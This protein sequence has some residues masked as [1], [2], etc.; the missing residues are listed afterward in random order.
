MELDPREPDARDRLRGGREPPRRG[1]LGV[2]VVERRHV[3]GEAHRDIRRVDRRRR[4]RTVAR[5]RRAA[6]H[7]PRGVDHDLHEA[8]AAPRVHVGRREAPVRD[9][10]EREVLGR[11]RGP[12]ELPL[13]VDAIVL[14]GAELDEIEQR[15]PR[16]R[17]ERRG[18]AVLERPFVGGEPGER[19]DGRGPPGIEREPVVA[20]ERLRGVAVAVGVP[21]QVASELV[22]ALARGHDEDA[23]ECVAVLRVHAARHQLHAGHRPDRHLCVAAP[24]HIERL[25]AVDLDLEILRAAPAHMRL[26]VR[27]HDAGLRAEH[28]H[29]A[30]P[31]VGLE[32]VATHLVARADL[33][34][35]HASLV[36]VAHHRLERVHDALRP[37]LN[38]ARR[39]PSRLDAHARP[40]R[41]VPGEQRDHLMLARGNAIE[42]VAP[43][44][45]GHHLEPEPGELHRRVLPR[46]A[47]T[48]PDDAADRSG[49]GGGRS[50][51]GGRRAG[52]QEEHQGERERPNADGGIASQRHA[53]TPRPRSGVSRFHFM[54]RCGMPRLRAECGRTASTRAWCGRPG[55]PA[56]RSEGALRFARRR[57]GVKRECVRARGRAAGAVSAAALPRARGPRAPACSWSDPPAPGTGR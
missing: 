18:G 14:A 9:P 56:A 51:R 26:A 24:Q 4:P 42:A 32:V 17:H 52:R 28:V 31:A 8:A 12:C 34:R 21:A 30:T 29:D 53:G 55:G 6:G 40:A 27:V 43:L 45:V 46:N 13:C 22:A 38:V 5:D 36:A 7:G 39:R 48:E 11:G 20:V 54:V 25:D 1:D 19:A 50:G 3:I 37:E 41:L 33:I 2:A 16:V 15:P 23:G 49:A 57:W 47:G 35:L 44:R 10:L